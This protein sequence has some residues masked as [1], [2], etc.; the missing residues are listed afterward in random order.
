MGRAEHGT[1][2]TAHIAGIVATAVTKA[3]ASRDGMRRTIM[4]AFPDF[5]MDIGK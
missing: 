5:K 3:E 2:Y 1:S 4:K